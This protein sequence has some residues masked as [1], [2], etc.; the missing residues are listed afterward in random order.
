MAVNGKTKARLVLADGSQ[1]E[2][3]SFGYEGS[4][5]GEVVFN[6]GMVG[7]PETLTD[8]SYR[9]Q[10]LTLTYP[11]IGNYGVPAA[12]KDCPLGLPF[13]SNEIQIRALIVSDYSEEYSHWAAKQSLADWLKEHKVPAI[14]GIDTRSLTIKLREH[15]T[16][17]GKLIYEKDVDQYDP[18]LVNLLPE[19][20]IKEP[21]FYGSGDRRI[22]VIDCG[23]KN[24]IIQCLVKR[25]VEVM[26]VPWDYDLTNEK[27][28]G[29][30]VSNGPGDPKQASKTIH[31]LRRMLTRNVPMFGICLGHQL[32]SLAIGADTFKLKYGHRS[33]NQPVIEQ[34]TN[35]CYITSQNHGYAV[36]NDSLPE[37]WEVWF[38]NL[39]DNTNEG[40]RHQSLPIRS[41]QFHPEAAPGPVDTEYLFDELVE[42]VNKV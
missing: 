41:C 39:N 27:F 18:S 7:Y 19:V 14:T 29:V 42:M 12:N 23:G 26:C 37:G 31:Q 1:Y 8:P 32:L 30:M 33:Q 17:L 16:M 4:S 40:I 22:V 38:K 28:H 15:G 34:G 2:G 6:T 13:E 9:G 24:N 20:S 3:F 10:I 21:T 11:L 36:D 35:R 5:A 25:G